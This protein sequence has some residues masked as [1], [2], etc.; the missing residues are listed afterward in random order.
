MGAPPGSSIPDYELQV[1]FLT[2]S[3]K[4]WNFKV[5]KLFNV[6]SHANYIARI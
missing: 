5:D 2:I 4:M 3:F 6:N 1:F